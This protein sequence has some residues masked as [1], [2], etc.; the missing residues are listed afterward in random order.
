LDGSSGLGEL[1]GIPPT[2]KRVEVPGVVFYRIAGGKIVEFRGQLDR[3]SLMQQLGV[4]S[5]PDKPRP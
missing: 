1:Q 4:V 5:G 2:G 3:M